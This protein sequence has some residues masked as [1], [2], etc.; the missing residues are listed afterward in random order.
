[1]KRKWS[2]CAECLRNNYLNKHILFFIL[3]NFILLYFVISINVIMLHH[4]LL[5]GRRKTKKKT[6]KISF[7]S[8]CHRLSLSLNFILL[9]FSLNIT[10]FCGLIIIIIILSLLDLFVF[11]LFIS[12]SN[13]SFAHYSF[14]LEFNVD[15]D[16]FKLLCLTYPILTWY[17]FKLVL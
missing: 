10:N 9:L 13:Q 11:V 15:E 6:K 7:A 3:F 5:F 4:N 14:K 8:N 16:H 2:E 1:M 12:F 17:N